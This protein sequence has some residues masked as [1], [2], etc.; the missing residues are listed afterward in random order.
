MDAQRRNRVGPAF[1]A[2]WTLALVLGL[3]STSPARSAPGV[4]VRCMTAD[5]ASVYTD[6]PC[7]FSGGRPAPMSTALV[8]RLVSEAHVAREQGA[9]TALPLGIGDDM[10]S[11]TGITRRP[12]ADGCARTPRQL[13][14]DLRGSLVLGDV[15]R[16]AES[17]HWVG[18]HSRES[19]RTMDRLAHLLGHQAVATQYYAAQMASLSDDD[20]RGGD[21][22]ILQVMLAGDGAPSMI[23][24]DVQRYAGC[25]FVR[26]PSGGATIA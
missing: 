17:Y 8:A 16:L 11:A 22:G 7:A 10:Q 4:I 13:A 5:G 9:D 14:D 6:Q 3:A 19:R 15:N 2:S 24:F 18:M 21:G 1:L 12:A 20:S 23:E 26:F 25:Y